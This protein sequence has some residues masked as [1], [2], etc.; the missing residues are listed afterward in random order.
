MSLKEKYKWLK[1]LDFILIDL[2]C[3]IVSFFQAY[4][5]KFN[6]FNALEK[7]EWSTLFIMLCFINL[8]VMFCINP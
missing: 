1:H 3:L 4:Y 5:L 6:T 8:I 2:F 7:Q